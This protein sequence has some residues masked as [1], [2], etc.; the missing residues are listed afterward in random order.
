MHY[1]MQIFD[2]GEADVQA[3]FESEELR[4]LNQKLDEQLQLTDSLLINVKEYIQKLQDPS[5]FLS[6]IK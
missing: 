1:F 2:R 4:L 5:S 6:L 3:N